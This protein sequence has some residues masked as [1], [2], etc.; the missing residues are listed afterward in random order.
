MNYALS[1]SVCSVGA[2]FVTEGRVEDFNILPPSNLLSEFENDY[3]WSN[4]QDGFDKAILDPTI[5]LDKFA[6]LE[7]MC[8][9]LSDGIKNRTASIM[10]DSSYNSSSP[11]GPVETSVVI[12]APSTDM[13]NK[14]HWVKGW[15][16]VT[17]SASSQS[18]YRS[19]LVGVIASLTIL[20]IIV[21][22]NN[23]TVG[24]VIIAVDGLTVMQQAGGD[25]P[26]S[27]DQECFDYLQIIRAWIK[28]SPLTFTV[29]QVKG[30]QTDLVAYNQ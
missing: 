16:K 1:I 13:R 30:H 20:D 25:W 12:M 27:L 11:I 4:I 5:L 24:A 23:I 14:Q 19:K 7:D 17:G 21:C 15:N 29:Q 3:T 28:L 6:L 9:A 10:S 2:S 26:L 8:Q 22:H 18:A